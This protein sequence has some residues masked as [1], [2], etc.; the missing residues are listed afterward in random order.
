MK[1][2]QLC[3]FCVFVR[4]SPPSSTSVPY[5][6]LTV[7]CYEERNRLLAFYSPYLWF[8]VFFSL[9]ELNRGILF[10]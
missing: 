4:L 5:G 6:V 2:T 7:L 3:V 9:V 8:R 1:C 10:P